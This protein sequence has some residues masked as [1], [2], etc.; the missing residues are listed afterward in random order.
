VTTKFLTYEQETELRKLVMEHGG[1]DGNVPVLR[2]QTALAPFGFSPSQVATCIKKMKL[3][4]RPRGRPTEMRARKLSGSKRRDHS[5][6]PG[7]TNL[8]FRAGPY[9]F[10][11][12]LADGSAWTAEAADQLAAVLEQALG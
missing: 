7:K 12:R 1:A 2:I 9:V 5:T 11:T 6:T 8:V 10:L 3:P 4:Q